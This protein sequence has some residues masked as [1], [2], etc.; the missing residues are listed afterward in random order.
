VSLSVILKDVICKSCIMKKSMFPG[1]HRQELARQSNSESHSMLPVCSV[2]CDRTAS[3]PSMRATAWSMSFGGS[4]P[5]FLRAMTFPVFGLFEVNMKQFMEWTPEKVVSENEA[6]QFLGVTKF[7][8]RSWR[9][10]KTGVPY[11]R[12]GRLCR[13]RVSDLQQFLDAHRVEPGGE[14]I[15]SK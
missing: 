7:C 11:V 4:I 13:Y 6:A 15:S 10:K 3:R 14:R 9:T 8:L 1:L 12:V 2:A 5:A